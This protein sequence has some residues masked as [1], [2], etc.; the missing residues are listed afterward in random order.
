MRIALDPW[1]SDYGA[2]VTVA[3]EIDASDDSVR[4]VD[5][6]VEAR[7]WEPVSPPVVPLPEVTAI[8]DGVMRTEANA[9]LIEGETRSLALFCSFATGAVVFGPQGVRIA[10]GAVERLFLVGNGRSAH[11]VAVPA[12]SGQPVSLLYRA[13]SSSAETPER[14]REALT[15]QMRQS[16]AAVAEKLC[17]RG[18]LILADGNLTFVRTGSPAVGVIK[19]VQRMYLSAGAAAI[20]ERL[21]PG[22]RTPLFRI[23]GSAA[24]DGYDV[25][26]CYLRLAR[27]QPIQHSFAGVVRLEVKAS[28]GV[29]SAVALLD[30]AA[31]KVSALASRPPKDPRAP[32]NLTPI[33]GLERQLRRSL[34]DAQL[35]RRGIEKALR[36]MLR[37]DAPWA[38]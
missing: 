38:E 12:G 28:L 2:Q 4:S 20:L 36:A 7:A 30:Q 23:R 13:L 8:I 6:Q 15:T 3:H 35:V 16:E 10:E 26:S 11:D 9:V 31:V 1:G 34:G 5:D 21:Q 37:G 27:P 24:R 17:E 32:Q 19:S 33:R 18:R 29:Q 22:E 25:F 14:L